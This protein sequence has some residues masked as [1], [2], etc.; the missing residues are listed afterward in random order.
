[1]DYKYGTAEG[2]A[3]KEGYVFN[4][5]TDKFP[6]GI[7]DAIA[8]SYFFNHFIISFLKKQYLHKY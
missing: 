7:L 6:I 3:G 2:A 1:V 5:I 4:V 8:L